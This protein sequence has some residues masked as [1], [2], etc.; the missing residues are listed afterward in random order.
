MMLLERSML[1]GAAM[2]KPGRRGAPVFALSN[3][4]YFRMV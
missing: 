2:K 1:P 4:R 3:E